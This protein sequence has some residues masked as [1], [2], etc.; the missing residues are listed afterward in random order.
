MLKAFTKYRDSRLHTLI[1]LTE[2]TVDVS[3]DSRSWHNMFK[4]ITSSFFDTAN[5]EKL[6]LRYINTII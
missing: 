1:I 3:I 6:F 5:N 4:R 2:K